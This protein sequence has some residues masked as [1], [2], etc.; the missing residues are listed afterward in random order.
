[1]IASD[2]IREVLYC[3]L[4]NAK[5]AGLFALY[6]TLKDAPNLG[7][8][9]EGCD[10]IGFPLR[11]LDYQIIMAANGQSPVDN[12]ITIHE[13]WVCLSFVEKALASPW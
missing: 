8:F 12:A 3:C 9:I 13:S 1:L 2:D 10:T 5:S 11:E 7:L 4:D 6:D